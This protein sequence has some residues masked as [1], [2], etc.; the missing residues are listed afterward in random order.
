MSTIQKDILNNKIIKNRLNTRTVKV[1]RY[2]QKAKVSAVL[3][4]PKTC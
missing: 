1:K 3:A 4:I 2:F